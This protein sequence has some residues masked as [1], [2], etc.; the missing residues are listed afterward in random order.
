VVQ[1]WSATGYMQIQSRSWA[2]Q[3][4]PL[5]S[6]VTLSAATDATKW[7]NPPAMSSGTVA[8]P[9]T[10]PCAANQVLTGLEFTHAYGQNTTNSEY[11][12]AQCTTLATGSKATATKPSLAATG[13]ATDATGTLISCPS[14]YYASAFSRG[15]TANSTLITDETVALVCS[16]LMAPTSSSSTALIIGVVVGVLVLV[17]VAVIVVR[18]RRNQDQE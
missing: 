1:Q 15:H 7:L 14:G 6:G 16:Q 4:A 9:D 18:R 8:T 13:N 12:S 11:T 2:L 10:W 5:P 17:I 3:C